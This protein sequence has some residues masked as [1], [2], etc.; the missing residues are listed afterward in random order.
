MTP[1]CKKNRRPHGGSLF[2]ARDFACERKGGAAEPCAEA[3]IGPCG[4]MW[5]AIC[6]SRLRE[7]EIDAA[8]IA[9]HGRWGEDGTVQGLLEMTAIPYTGSGVLGSALA[10]D[11]CLGKLLLMS[12]DVP[13]PAYAICRPQ[14]RGGLSPAFRGKAGQRRIDRRH[15][16]R[17]ARRRD[18]SGDQDRLS[19]R[20][21]APHR[22][23]REGREI[24][25]AIV[26]GLALPI[27]EVRAEI[28]LLRLRLEVHE[29][30]DRVSRAGRSWT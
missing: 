12:L 22:A 15:I 11:K 30:H 3:A 17:A 7:E 13:T 26:N 2:R 24:T 1:C 6:P 14:E 29:R 10:M 21:Q 5:D 4:S 16:D 28:G 9:L 18:R 19:A 23:I 20:Q 8:F 25:V 27:V